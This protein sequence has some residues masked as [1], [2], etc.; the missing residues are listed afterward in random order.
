MVAK[1]TKITK[2]DEARAK[3]FKHCPK[4]D[5]VLTVA[6]FDRTDWETTPFR[7]IPAHCSKCRTIAKSRKAK[8][9]TEYTK[10]LW[11]TKKRVRAE[12]STGYD[13]LIP[14]TVFLVVVVKP[15]KS[16]LPGHATHK[17]KRYFMQYNAR[18]R[19]L[20]MAEKAKD[21]SVRVL[22]LTLN[23][24]SFREI[25]DFESIKGWELRAA[26]IAERIATPVRVVPKVKRLK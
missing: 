15:T 18:A 16:L 13:G 19:T 20:A 4:C 10:D 25:V 2:D 11:A 1:R 21:N 17:A 24:A 14:R 6:A 9:S 22:E 7:R 3:G 12:M 8:L 23:A 26:D 5:L